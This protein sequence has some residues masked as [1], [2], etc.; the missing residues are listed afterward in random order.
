[1]NEETSIIIDQNDT[2]SDL[3][4]VAVAVELRPMELHMPDDLPFEEWVKIGRKLTRSDQVMQWW[5]GDWARFGAGD[6]DKKGWRKQG[7]LKEFAEA[8]GIN[9]QTLRNLAWVSGNVQLSR[10]RDSLEWAKHAEV[11]ALPPKEQEKWLAKTEAEAL[12]RAELRRQIRQSQGENNALES[13]GP[14]IKFISKQLDDLIHWLKKQ[15]SDFWDADRKALWKVRLQPIVEIW[16]T[17]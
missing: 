7:R 14:V 3:D 4:L 2:R 11:A 13:D 16:K 15:P 6:K 17:L 1:M 10:R 12:P 5:L 9:Y 8:N